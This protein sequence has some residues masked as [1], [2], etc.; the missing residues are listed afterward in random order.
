MRCRLVAILLVAALLA[1]CES[2]ST[3]ET[4]SAPTT[5]AQDSS[6]GPLLLWHGWS[7]GDRQALGRLVDRYNRQQRDGRIVLQSVPLAG[8]AAELRAAVA[9][10]SGPHLILI[11]NTWIGGLAEA[12]VLLPLD[13]LVPAQETGTLLPVTLAGAQARDAAGTLRLYGAPVRFDTLALYYNAANLTEPPA[14]TATMLAVG[15]GLSDPEA[16]PPIWGLALNLSYDNMIGYLYAFDGRIFDDNGQVALGTAGRAGAEQW[17]AWLIA[18]Q[19]DP[20]IL[21]RSESSILVDRELKDGRAFMTFD[22]AHQIGVYRGLWGNQIGIA[23]LPRLSETGRAPRPY[24]RADVLAI[25]NLAGVSEREAAARFIRFMISE[26]AQAV[27]LQSDMQPASR[28]LALTG[29]SPQEIAAQVFRVQAE[30]GLPMPNSSVRA[31][32]EQEIKRMQRQASLGLTTPSDAVTEADRRLR[33]RLE[34]SA[35]MP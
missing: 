12:G 11:P 13:N 18:L 27:L 16:Q 22:W 35:P 31:F 26:E 28:T 23:P 21:A 25:N 20:R 34:P 8:F 4:S 2:G 32:V 17:L 3:P 30:Q 15:R 33:E 9:A 7:G 10:G 14:D 19:N 29:D 1:A 6:V 5:V 24:V